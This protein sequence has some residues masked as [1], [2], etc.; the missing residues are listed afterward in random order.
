MTRI[1]YETT[2]SG[3]GVARIFHGMRRLAV[4]LDRDTGDDG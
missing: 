2:P 1:V 4:E 3:I